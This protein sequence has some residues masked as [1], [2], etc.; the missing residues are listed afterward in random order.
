M[1]DGNVL[2]LQV[3]KCIIFFC[4]FL[5]ERKWFTH[6]QKSS[7]YQGDE[8]LISE[9]V[10][11]WHY[12]SYPKGFHLQRG[13]RRASKTESKYWHIQGKTLM[14]VQVFDLCLTCLWSM[15]DGPLRLGALINLR[16]YCGF[17]HHNYSFR[18]SAFTAFSEPAHFKNKYFIFLFLPAVLNS[19]YTEHCLT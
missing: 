10:N 8:N 3:V 18:S 12:P 17:Q 14:V 6:Q 19:V 4:L 16:R 2:H 9:G 5:K 7:R 11:V 1:S 13:N 15:W